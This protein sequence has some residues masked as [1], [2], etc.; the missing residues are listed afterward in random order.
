MARNRTTCKATPDRVFAVLADPRA[1]AYFVAGTRTIRR[2]DPRWPEPG[3]VFHHSLGLG[4]TLIRDKTVAVETEPPRRL[5]VRP[6]MMPLAIN[7]TIFRLRPHGQ[8]TL[9]EIEE[10]L[11][12]G[13]ASHRLVAPVVDRLLWLRNHVLLRRLRKVVEARQRQL[14]P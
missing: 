13:P 3:S 8:V 11:V 1:Y 6:S 14:R 2:F 9:V 12:A 5:V 4:V 10:Y 7:E